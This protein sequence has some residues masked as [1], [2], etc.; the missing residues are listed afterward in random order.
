[1]AYTYSVCGVPWT[2]SFHDFEGCVALLKLTCNLQDRGIYRSH[3][4]VATP[5]GHSH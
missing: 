5:Y 3:V 4:A 1:M 2:M